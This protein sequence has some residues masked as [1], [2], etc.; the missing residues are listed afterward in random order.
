MTLAIRTRDVSSGLVE[1]VKK[2]VWSLDSRIPVSDV[3]TM[4]ELMAVSLAQQ[5]FNML[6]LGLFAALALLL[7]AVGIYGM[8][9]FRVGQRMHDP[10]RRSAQVPGGGDQ[11][12]AHDPT[13]REQQGPGVGS[14]RREGEADGLRRRD[15]EQGREKK[16]WAGTQGGTRSGRSGLSLHRPC[17]PGL[18][19]RIRWGSARR[20]P[21]S[22]MWRRPPGPRSSVGCWSPYVGRVGPA[23]SWRRPV[24]DTMMVPQAVPADAPFD[25]PVAASLRAA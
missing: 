9:A 3:H 1:E 2:Q 13:G 10:D 19:P 8:M 17:R 12:A 5:R 15:D 25:S 20:R 4:D 16:A 7:A 23:A 14:P 21:P 22:R 11:L 6:L 18:S 24:R